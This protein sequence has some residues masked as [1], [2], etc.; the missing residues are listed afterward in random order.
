MPNSNVDLAA[1]ALARD[2]MAAIEKAPSGDWVNSNGRDFDLVA[3]SPLLLARA[4]L[5]LA[6]V[7]QP[8]KENPMTVRAKFMVRAIERSMWGNR[9]Q[10]LVT[11]KLVPVTTGS[12]ENKQFYD[13]SPS[14]SMELGVLNASASAQFELGKEYYVDFTRADA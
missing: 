13:A 9:D 14:G 1:V 10:N 3:N 5:A 7:R 11:V 12:E 2:V 4:V 6:E 8:T